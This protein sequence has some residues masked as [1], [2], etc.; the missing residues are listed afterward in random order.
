LAKLVDDVPDN[1]EGGK[2]GKAKPA[3]GG[4]K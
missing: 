3:A 1:E 4:G 2:G